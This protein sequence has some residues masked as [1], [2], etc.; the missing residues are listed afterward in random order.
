MG[1]QRMMSDA[2][3]TAPHKRQTRQ[4]SQKHPLTHR[5]IRAFFV[6]Q[7]KDKE[8][9]PQKAKI[10][11]LEI[12]GSYHEAYGIVIQRYGFFHN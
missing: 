4:L 10:P 5:G 2:G 12:G 6:C 8:L 11:I 1:K 7:Q 3:S 9:L